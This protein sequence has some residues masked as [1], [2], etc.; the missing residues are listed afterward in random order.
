L[1]II[2]PGDETELLLLLLFIAIKGT[3]VALCYFRFCERLDFSKKY[4]SFS[5][6]DLNCFKKRET[7]SV[8]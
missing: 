1:L 8:L 2:I 3:F 5:L 6:D 4:F 7:N